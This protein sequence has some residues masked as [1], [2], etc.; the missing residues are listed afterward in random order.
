MQASISRNLK[1]PHPKSLESDCLSPFA[2][3]MTQSHGGEGGGECVSEGQ[4]SIRFIKVLVSSL[5]NSNILAFVSLKA[6]LKTIS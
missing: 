5:I 3:I 4:F 1:R 6:A 2:A